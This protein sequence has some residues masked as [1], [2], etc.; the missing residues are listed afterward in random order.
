MKKLIIPL[1]LIATIS[2][3]SCDVLEEVAGTVL[4]TGDGETADLPGLS[5]GEVISGL[6]EALNVGIKNSV[7]LTSVTDGFLGNNEIRL[8]FPEDAQKVKEKALKWGLDNQV[9]KFETTL[10]RAAEEACKEA[11]PIFKDAI[12]KMSIQDAFGILNGGD[13]AATNYLKGATSSALKT[14]F[15]PKVEVAIAKVKLTEYW[16]PIITKYNSAMT[17]T[18]GEKLNP[19]L[20]DYVTNKAITGLFIMVAKEENKIRLDPLARVT[21]ILQKVFGSIGK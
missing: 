2:I 4:S 18:G 21:D 14:A 15:L 3:V 13:G 12:L 7:D 6:K 1:A 17:L 10:N 11:L 5:E 16:N 9:E 8:P 20:N 19:D